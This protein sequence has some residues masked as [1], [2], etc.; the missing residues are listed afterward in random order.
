MMPATK[1]PVILQQDEEV[2]IDSVNTTK[3]QDLANTSQIRSHLLSESNTTNQQQEGRMEA[4]K[5]CDDSSEEVSENPSD[6]KSISSRNGSDDLE[7]ASEKTIRATRATSSLLKELGRLR[8]V[9]ILNL[10]SL[11]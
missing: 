1:F 6:L 9:S 4:S 8:Y 10:F 2:V 11:D 7:N 3:D 5:S